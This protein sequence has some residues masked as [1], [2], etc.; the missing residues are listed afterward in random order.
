MAHAVGENAVAYSIENGTELLR[1]REVIY[2]NTDGKHILVTNKDG[3][4]VCNGP[5][6]TRARRSNSTV[7]LDQPIGQTGFRFDQKHSA[8]CVSP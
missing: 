2:A 1:K 5:W 4:E 8:I 7:I 6:L 3:A